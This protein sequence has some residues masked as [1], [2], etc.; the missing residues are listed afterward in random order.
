VLSDE[1]D[2]K[3]TA[4]VVEHDVSLSGPSKRAGNF[5]GA[6]ERPRLEFAP[7]SDPGEGLW[8]QA[9]ATLLRKECLTSSTHV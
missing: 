3:V 1:E 2:R 7:P 4:E 9:Y 6:L 8:R 5:N